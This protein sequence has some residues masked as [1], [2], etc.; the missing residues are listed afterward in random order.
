M[1]KTYRLTYEPT[2]VMHALFDRTAAS[3]GWKISARVLREYIEYFGPKTEQLDLLAQEGKAVF[4]SFTEKVQDGNRKS[5]HPSSAIELS[6][7]RGLEATTR[8]GH[9]HPHGRLRR[10]PRAG[11]HAYC[12]QCQRLQSHRHTCRNASN[13][14]LRTLLL[15]DSTSPI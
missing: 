7:C 2:E 10:L 6:I 15:S 8:D 14:H 5:R 11:D 1:N 12:D 9:F 4:T 13:Y 3:Q